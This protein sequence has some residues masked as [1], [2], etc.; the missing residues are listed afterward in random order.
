MPNEHATEARTMRADAS[1][2]ARETAFIID[3]D[4][5]M[6]E[7][8]ERRLERR[9]FEPV[10]FDDPERLLDEIAVVSPA[11]LFT[12]LEMP[13]MR[14]VDLAAKARERGYRG[15]IVV[16]TASRERADLVA[17]IM[18]GAD[19]ILA[20]PV[21][22]GDLDLLIAKAKVRARRGLPAI[23]LLRSVLELVGQG[24]VLLDEECVPFYAN[25]RAREILDA[26][27]VHEVQEVLD[28]G[29]LAAHVMKEQGAYGGLVFLDVSKPDG[30]GARRLVG[31]ETHEVAGVAPGRTYIVLMH[32]FAEWR[33]LDEFHSRFWT[34]LSHRMRTPLTSA[35]NAVQILSAK[36][37]PL[38]VA[39]RERFL[40][41]GCRNIEKLVSSLD[42]L[43]KVFM[44]ESGEIN[45]YRSL[46]RVARELGAI[47]G[48]CER[49]GLIKGFKLRA[50]D[51]TALTCRSRLKEYVINGVEAMASWLGELPYVECTVTAND[52]V[53][54]GVDEPA[55]FITLIARGRTGESRGAL[56]EYFTFDE[57]RKE[58]ILEQLARALDG[59]HMV[60]ANDS[61]RLRL[62]AQPSFDKDRDLIHP[63][64]MML[65]RSDLERSAFHLVSIRLYGAV[66]D[67]R[68][69]S[70]L[71]EANLCALFGKDEWLVA[72]EERPDRF[73]L[74]VTGASQA[75]IEDAMKSLRERFASC[76]RERGEEFYPAI[77][78]EI[79]YSR[80][81]GA[82]SDPSDRAV[83]AAII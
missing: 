73:A 34:Y 83:F 80:E 25:S 56:K 2:T 36:D 72:R 38:D 47:L 12:D 32:D 37:E 23:E 76:C 62:P 78:W 11:F 16:A 41:I 6:A 17:A 22:D 46:I 68:R 31:F 1:G 53:E 45:A 10:R 49:N 70:Q 71:L 9:G 81:P 55:L 59:T 8:L 66:P 43:Q 51:C 69:F 29:K 20:K 77:R 67:V 7:L 65:E 35:R 60:A 40:D 13:L 18:N 24:V 57:I 48:E 50:P 75:R 39:E 58:L 82:C 15:T 21:K 5:L 14:G 52:G 79:T 33:K 3:D 30:T 27:G 44:V 26:A 54:G 61:L 64:H 74:L 19:E 63:L 42:G 28:R 4:P